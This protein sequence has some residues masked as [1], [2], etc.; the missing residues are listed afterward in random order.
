[1]CGFIGGVFLDPNTELD[2]PSALQAL[3]HRGP[4]DASWFKEAD[5]AFGHTRLAIIDKR[6]L[7]N[8]P[9]VSPEG[10]VLVFNGEIYNHNQLRDELFALGYKFQ[11]RSDTEVILHGYGAWGD[12]LVTR[13]DG[14]F[15]IAI[16]NRRSSELL[17]ARDRAGK[18]PLFYATL[19][20]QIIF[21]SEPKAIFASGAVTPTLCPQ[22]LPFILTFGYVPSPNT[23]YHN[24]KQVPPATW[25][26]FDA[27]GNWVNK[28]YWKVPF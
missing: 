17:L 1:M 21:A 10:N 3:R 24:L 4:D 28:R 18:K 26:K 11:T 25:V 6:S 2:M 8:Q 5:Y 7:A 9:M 13:L 20:T 14:M 27:Q 19:G 23:N 12:S 16:Y 15:A 22:A